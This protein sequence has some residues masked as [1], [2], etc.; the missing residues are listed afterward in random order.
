M[1]KLKQEARE[2]FQEKYAQLS[3]EIE[4]Y[5]GLSSNEMMAFYDIE[6]FIDSLIEKAYKAGQMNPS[7]GFLR[8]YLNECG[9]FEKLW[10]DEDIMKF[11]QIPFINLA[12]TQDREALIQEIMGTQ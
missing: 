2:E 8:Q 6:K 11:L 3:I 10:T 9:K 5:W 7:V 12:E 4:R 1:D